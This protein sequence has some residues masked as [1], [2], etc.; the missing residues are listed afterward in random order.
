MA[1]SFAQPVGPIQ[2]D[3]GNPLANGLELATCGEFFARIGRPSVRAASSSAT[4]LG[5]TP[6]G[7][8]IAFSGALTSYARFDTGYVNTVSDGSTVEAIVYSTTYPS[9]AAI[10]NLSNT[11]NTTGVPNGTGSNPTTGILC[12]S[13][14]PPC[15]VY[16]WGGTS[17]HERDTDTPFLANTKQHLVVTKAPGSGVG[18][19]LKLYVNGVLKYDG[20]SSAGGTSATGPYWY[21]GGRH[22]SATATIAG[23]VVKTAFWRR[24]LTGPEVADLYARPWQVFQSQSARI[25]TFGQPAA[26]GDTSIS[27]TSQALVLTA[28]AATVSFDVSISATSQALALTANQATITADT[29]VSASSQALTLTANAAT[30]TLGVAIEATSQALVLT[31]N[32]AAVAFDV[33]ISATSQALTLTAYQASVAFGAEIAATTQA[34]SLTTAAASIAFDVGI[35]ASLDALLLTTYAATVQSG[36]VAAIPVSVFLSGSSD[37]LVMKDGGGILISGT[38]DAAVGMR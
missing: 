2:I 7:I 31:A 12:F 13:G 22:N 17:S 20:T 35:A 24:A 36:A 1:R 19:A 10:A 30:V 9:L 29:S 26:G 18:T 25:Y 28:N 32:Q 38:G 4:S 27:A 3:A 34:L 37:G 23:T 15:D 16:I 14:G 5:A 6:D 33:S 11:S 21:I 8:G